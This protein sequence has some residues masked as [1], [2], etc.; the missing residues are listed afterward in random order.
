VLAGVDGNIVSHEISEITTTATPIAR[1]WGGL[2]VTG[3]HGKMPHMG[4][5]LV[6]DTESLKALDTTT[7]GNRTSL[8]E[9]T[10]LDDYPRQTSDIVALLVLEH[11]IEVQNALTR[12]SFISRTRLANGETL[13]DTALDKLTTPVL[14][15][16]FMAHEAPLSDTV[17]GTSGYAEWFQAQGPKTKEGRSLR[18][19][20]LHTRTFRY[21]LSYLIY[22]P[23]I[24]AL[25]DVVRAH[26]FTR[27]R[28][29]LAGEGG[30]AFAHLTADLRD[31]ISAILRET[32]PEILQ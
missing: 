25:P 7:W 3:T 23:V 11:Q 15:S 17:Q 27:I 8:A 19:L 18:Q 12:L 9:F 2:Y 16:L 4:N 30:P 6:K 1:R 14:E 13:D 10:K 20:D 21:P 31:D 24:D 29:V 26:L 28:A 22:S 5:L 32:N